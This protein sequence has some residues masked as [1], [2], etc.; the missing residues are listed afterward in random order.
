[1][2]ALIK[3]SVVLKKF[4]NASF[5]SLFI[6]NF[7]GTVYAMEGPVHHPDYY[8][9]IIHSIYLNGFEKKPINGEKNAA[10]SLSIKD[11]FNMTADHA[12]LYPISKDSVFKYWSSGRG[13][14]PNT[15]GI[16]ARDYTINYAAPYIEYSDPIY[17]NKVSIKTQHHLGYATAFSI[18]VKTST[19][20]SSWTTIY[21]QSSSKKLSDGQLEIYYDGST[22]S[23]YSRAIDQPDE[24][25][26]IDFSKNN[27]KTVKIYGLRF[28]AKKMSNVFI[29]F[30]LLSSL[31]FIIVGNILFIV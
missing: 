14:Y 21:K 3:K 20:N 27:S 13:L 11:M 30:C 31:L 28:I 4:L 15:V 18:D 10:L 26:I 19:S 6:L 1:M 8:A 17:I 29:Y 9:G 2:F 5:V 24:E 16:S 22:W 25:A 12:R 23:V 7:F